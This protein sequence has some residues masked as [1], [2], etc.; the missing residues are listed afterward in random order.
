LQ[1]RKNN[2]NQT[3]NCD[4]Q[5]K[6]IK[7]KTQFCKFVLLNRK[8]KMKICNLVSRYEKE[9]TQK[10]NLHFCK[11]VAYID[12]ICINFSQNT[13]NISFETTNHA[14]KTDQNT[15]Q[16]HLQNNTSLLSKAPQTHHKVTTKSTQICI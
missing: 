7:R 1:K 8:V 3:Q 9:K 11:S 4:L 14:H 6:I 5:N 16:K 15:P 2:K 12:V 13:L 10:E